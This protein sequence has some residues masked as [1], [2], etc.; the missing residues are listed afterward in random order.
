MWNLNL[1]EKLLHDYK[2]KEIVEFLRYGWPISHNGCT[3]SSMVPQNWPG[4]IVNS[5]HIKDYFEKD[6]KTMQYWG[7]L[8]IT[9]SIA[10]LSYHH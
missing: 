1:L 9:H 4:V 8:M 2:H 10:G 6:I 7:L 5:S 3:G